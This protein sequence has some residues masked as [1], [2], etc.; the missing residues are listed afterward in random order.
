MGTRELEAILE[1]AR[2]GNEARNV[3]GALVYADGVFL[4]V[5]EGEREVLEPLVESIRSDKRHDSMKVFH[6]R[7]VTRRAFDDWRMAYIGSST[8]EV[9]RWAGLTGTVTI[10][11]LLQ[12]LQDDA[13]LVP[14]ILVHV[15]E[16]IAAQSG[17]V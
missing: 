14:K 8:A 7:E 9:S 2:A 17:K 5:L 13:S 10:D 3:T 4:Q 11:R 16:A 6:S 1:D 12:H 15:V